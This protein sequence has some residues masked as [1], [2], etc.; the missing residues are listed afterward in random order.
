MKVFLKLNGNNKYLNFWQFK[1]FKVNLVINFNDM[2]RD[3]LKYD[4]SELSQL[5]LLSVLSKN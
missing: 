3:Y 4:E 5:K 1:I 2:P